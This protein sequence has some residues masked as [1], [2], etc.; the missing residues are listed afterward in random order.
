MS[1]DVNK[2]GVYQLVI[3]KEFLFVAG[4]PNAVYI[5]GHARKNRLR[6]ESVV[7]LTNSFTQYVTSI[8][9]AN[10]FITSQTMLQYTQVIKTCYQNQQLCFVNKFHYIPFY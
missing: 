6:S 3:S 8:I 5:N 4:P 10:M 9:H 2:C 1:K 7:A